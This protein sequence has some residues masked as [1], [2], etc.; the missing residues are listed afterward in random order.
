M[1]YEFFVVE[2]CGL[3]LQLFL[4]FYPLRVNAY[5]HTRSEPPIPMLTTSVIAL[6]VKPFQAPDMTWFVN[7]RI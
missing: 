1:Y 6:P 5:K 3:W 7:S 4:I 2:G